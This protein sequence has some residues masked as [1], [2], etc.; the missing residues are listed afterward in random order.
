MRDYGS[1]RARNRAIN[2]VN[3]ISNYL[4]I[5]SR[6]SAW[7]IRSLGGHT[8]SILVLLV[9]FVAVGRVIMGGSISD[10]R[11]DT[12]LPSILDNLSQQSFATQQLMQSIRNVGDMSRW[13][14]SGGNIEQFFKGI[15]VF[16]GQ[17][18]NLVYMLASCVLCAVALIGCV[19]DLLFIA[20]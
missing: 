20:L 17:L 7:Q 13:A 5:D 15:A 10:I 1:D 6:F 2:N 11:I 18:G 14:D 12:L 9:V 8:L 19:F 4:A 3:T 16:F